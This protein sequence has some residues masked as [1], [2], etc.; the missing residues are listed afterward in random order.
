[1]GKGTITGG[2]DDGRYSIKLDFGKAA[3]DAQRQRISKRLAALG[4]EIASAQ[5]KYDTEK[6]KENSKRQTA[7]AAIAAYTASSSAVPRVPDVV[8]AALKKYTAAAVELNIQQGKTAQANA[9]LEIL[10]TQQAQLQKDDAKW[11][12]MELEATRD[13]WCVD[14]T[15]DATG[16]VATIEIPGE[17]K[18]FLIAAEGKKAT[19]ADGLVVARE[20]QSAA[21]VFFN[22]AILPGWQKFRPTYRAGTITALDYAKDTADITLSTDDVSSAQKLGINQTDTLENVPVEY[23]T[24]NSAAF[25]IG[26][27]CV[28]K[29]EEQDWTQPKVIGFFDNP[30]PCGSGIGVAYE[31]ADGMQYAVLTPSG[32]YQ[33]PTGNWRAKKEKKLTGGN[34]PWSGTQIGEYAVSN[35]VNADGMKYGGVV[36]TNKRVPGGSVTWTFGGVAGGKPFVA[37]I[38]NNGTSAFDLSLTES[39]KRLRNLRAFKSSEKN[40][41]FAIDIPPQRFQ[42]FT[43]TDVSSDGLR[44]LAVKKTN[45]ASIPGILAPVGQFT[46]EEARILTIALPI[47][48]DQEYMLSD[49]EVHTEIPAGR[50]D[51]PDDDGYNAST[52]PYAVRKDATRTG[53]DLTGNTSIT[54]TRRLDMEFTAPIHNTETATGLYFRPDGGIG[55]DKLRLVQ[56]RDDTYSRIGAQS[57]EDGYEVVGSTLSRAGDATHNLKERLTCDIGGSIFEIADIDI[58][59]SGDSRINQV[60]WSV[61][62]DAVAWSVISSRNWVIEADITHREIKL[63]D[64]QFKVLVY[65][66]YKTVGRYTKGWTYTDDGRDGNIFN[67]VYTD[68]PREKEE[69][70]ECRFVVWH[71]GAEIYEKAFDGKVVPYREYGLPGGG[72]D[73]YMYGYNS[74]DGFMSGETSYTQTTQYLGPLANLFDYRPEG[75][76][77]LD[78]EIK[79]AKDPMT[80]ALVLH[81]NI[82]NDG[83]GGAEAK[84]FVFDG[85]GVVKNISDISDIPPAAIPTVLISV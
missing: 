44:I 10:K 36:V 56:S 16:D 15:E 25:D 29:F 54:W 66:E 80:G 84:W 72:Y 2:G 43:A 83:W 52:S 75:S 38:Y 69:D 82:K 24:C 33:T 42:N 40:K 76:E 85:A 46:N 30:R 57:H 58:T 41:A 63:Y 27:I 59:D 22:A 37:Q 60:V 45:D 7:T 67:G 77:D 51:Y 62:S 13:V 3:R 55:E 28:I 31:G 79:S 23:M 18:H 73:I 47:P 53:S 48:S 14:L 81:L 20:V 61:D 71:A 32:T 64:R 39:P 8:A 35:G 6:T 78:F 5:S 19:S 50:P 70:N 4:P 68:A 34:F 9:A 65:L 11:S 26:D 74:D 21:Q 49:P 1:M 17:T 12:N